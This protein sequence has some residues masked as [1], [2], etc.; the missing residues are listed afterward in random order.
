LL[1]RRQLQPMR[2]RAPLR[3]SLMRIVLTL[4]TIPDTFANIPLSP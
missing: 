4:I 1:E 3:N 2:V